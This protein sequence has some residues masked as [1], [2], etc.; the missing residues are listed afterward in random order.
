VVSP[1]LPYPLS[2]GGAVR[3]Y[4][5]CRELSGQVDFLLA[6]FKEKGDVPEFDK[7]LEVFREVYVLDVDEPGSRDK[8]LP[9]QVRA[10]DS[11]SMQALIR[12]LCTSRSLDIVQIEYTHM[13]AFGEAA[14]ATPAILVE[15][16]LTYSLY[17]QLAEQQRTPAAWSEYHRWLSFERRAFGRYGAVWVMSDEDRAKA[18]AAGSSA[19]ST[20]VIP[21]G[22]DVDRFN[23]PAVPTGPTGIFYVGS[24]RHLPNILGFEKL[25]HEV[26]PR[27]WQSF[28]GAKLR[29]VAGP[30]PKRYWRELMKE[31][32]PETL[33]PR[34]EILSFVADLRSLYAHASVVV[35]PLLVS[36]G[37]NIKVMEAMACRKPVVST[38][39]GCYGLG[40]IDDHD[41]LIRDAS[42]DFADAIVAL[43]ADPALRL[44]IADQARRTVEERFDWK[45]IAAG[46]YES[47]TTL[48]SNQ[49]V[50]TIAASGQTET[51]E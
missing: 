48:L 9:E 2:H 42:A 17:R 45:A 31:D 41:A 20:F 46:A 11:S 43:L 32:Y 33:D 13:A 19:L 50:S 25:R 3:I 18:I 34:I 29:V 30:E 21:N 36:A 23:C 15:H 44:R 49:T 26:M 28:P 35:V 27:V 47:Y 24:F 39:V 12:E 4:N 8:T 37:T 16:D 10:H 51:S 7:L 5:L 6:C 22:V 1:Y 14:G 38:S 40:L